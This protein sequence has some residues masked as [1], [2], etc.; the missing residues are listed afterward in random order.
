MGIFDFFKKSNPDLTLPT[1][2]SEIWY[3]D[4]YAIW[5]QSN[6]EAF[7]HFCGLAKNSDNASQCRFLLGRDWNTL[8]GN[9]VLELVDSLNGAHDDTNEMVEELRNLKD[10]D[11]ETYE[12]LKEMLAWDL[13]RATQVLGMAYHGGWIDRDT[14]NQKS[15]EV[16]K[17]MQ[18]AFS[19]WTELI[20]YY[21][22]GYNSWAIESFD[23][24]IAQENIRYREQS[25]AIVKNHANPAYLV[26]WNLKL[27]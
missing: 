14:M 23:P 5:S 25:Y 17:V 9:A 18:R 2:D 24:E 12:S 1:N 19:S 22:K 3:R 7:Q 26:E 11:T 21:L 10:T 4:T 20:E 27:D 6:F 8:G 16:G 13:C 15:S